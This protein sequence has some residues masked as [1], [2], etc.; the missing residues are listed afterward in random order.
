VTRAVH[1]AAPVVELP[2]HDLDTE[3]GVLGA[4]LQPDDAA[5]ALSAL[6]E[7]VT[8]KTFYTGHNQL[9]FGHLCTLADAGRPTT[10]STLVR[11]LRDAGELEEVGGEVYVRMLEAEGTT[12]QM[13]PSLADEL[14]RLAL[15]RDAAEGG[16]LI[17]QHATNGATPAALSAEIR[18]L[19][20]HLERGATTSLIPTIVSEGDDL[21][22]SWADG[23]GVTVANAHEGR[24]L[25]AEV[26]IEHR[27]RE[28]HFGRFDIMSIRARADLAKKLQGQVRFIDWTTRLDRLCRMAADAVRRGAPVVALEPRLHDLTERHALYPLQPRGQTALVYMD[29]GG[30]KSTLSLVGAVATITGLRIA[31]LEPRVQGPVLVVDWE[32][33]Q[34][35]HETTLARLANGHNLDVGALRE[36]L[37][38]RPMAGR[39]ADDARRFRRDVAALRVVNVIVDSVVPAAGPE[40]EGSEAA[41]RLMS[42][43]RGLGPDVSRLMLGHVPK[44]EATSGGPARPFGS[45]FYWNL[46]R[47][48][49]EVRSDQDGDHLRMSLTHKKV[50]VGPKLPTFGLDFYFQPDS[51]VVS[52]LDLA[53]EPTLTK[54]A[55]LAE[56]FM[57]AIRKVPMT[58]KAIAVELDASEAVAGATGRKL[59]GKHKVVKIPLVPHDEDGSTFKWAPASS[60]QEPDS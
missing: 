43:L 31:G 40:A 2:P 18:D 4:A 41:V 35:E 10:T 20:D 38:Y 44:G 47:S 3:R 7:K 42:T 53:D 45:A 51:L 60:R 29:G 56:R 33:V 5:S 16:R 32:G 15:K 55:P 48:V 50:N 34:E 19:A 8:A 13:V 9:I 24:E 28:L 12:P 54:S 37:F 27:G 21:I 6:R 11:S 58:T 14:V 49:W 46:S 22:F 17:T 30:G 36:R 52:R 26:L 1:P 23:V 59:Y 57:L 25:T 39:L